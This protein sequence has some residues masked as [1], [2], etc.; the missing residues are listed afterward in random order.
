MNLKQCKESLNGTPEEKAKALEWL[1]KEAPSILKMK[2][3]VTQ[4]Q[5]ESLCRDYDK[6]KDELKETFLAMHNTKDLKKYIS[7]NLT[8]RNWIKRRIENPI[9]V[10]PLKKSPAEISDGVIRANG[11]APLKSLN[12]AR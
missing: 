10:V 6:H 12:Q 1:K 11:Q 5:Y 8:V 4:K 9:G 7:A 3:P 2:E